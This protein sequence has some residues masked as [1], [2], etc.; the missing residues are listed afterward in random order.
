MKLSLKQLI[1]LLLKHLL[2]LLMKQL[3]QRLT[4][5]KRCYCQLHFQPCI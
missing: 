4:K 1:R 2:M 3:M 5:L